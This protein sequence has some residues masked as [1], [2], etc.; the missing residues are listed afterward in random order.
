[1]ENSML[2][3]STTPCYEPVSRQRKFLRRANQI[4]PNLRTD[5]PRPIAMQDLDYAQ[6]YPQ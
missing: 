3:A 1:M 5:L 2:T 6:Y 4:N